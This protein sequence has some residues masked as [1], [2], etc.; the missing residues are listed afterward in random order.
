LPPETLTAPAGE[1]FAATGGLTLAEDLPAG[2]YILQVVATSADPKN[3]K[4]ARRAVQQL[5]FDIK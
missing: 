4:R 3:A 2:A 5:S 1:P